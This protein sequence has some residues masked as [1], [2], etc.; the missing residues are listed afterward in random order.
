MVAADLASLTFSRTVA[1]WG[2]PGSTGKFDEIAHRV[3][4]ELHAAAAGL[5]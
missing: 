2:K 1:A 4:R 5:S 3:L